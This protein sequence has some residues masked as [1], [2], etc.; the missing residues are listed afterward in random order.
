MGACALDC[1]TQTPCKLGTHMSA[2]AKLHCVAAAPRFWPWGCA[3]PRAKSLAA[4]QLPAR[5]L[6]CPPLPSL[7]FHVGFPTHT[8]QAVIHP[9]AA[10][11]SM[12]PAPQQGAS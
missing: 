5:L 1:A 3:H 4:P 2:A 6:R 10:N 11:P 8:C 7:P 9:P 12:Q